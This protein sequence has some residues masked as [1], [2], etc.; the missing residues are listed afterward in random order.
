M[1]AARAGIT[2]ILKRYIKSYK[3]EKRKNELGPLRRF[4]TE[5]THCKDTTV[6][7]LVP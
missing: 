3:N 4:S 1:L 5:S 6:F 7:G 2:S